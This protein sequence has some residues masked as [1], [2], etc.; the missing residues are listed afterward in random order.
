MNRCV[1]VRKISIFKTS[2]AILSN[3]CIC[4]FTP[5]HALHIRPTSSTRKTFSYKNAS[6]HYRSP[7]LTPLGAVCGTVYYGWM[8]FTA[9]ILDCWTKA[10]KGQDILNITLTGFVWKKNLIWDAPRMPWA[11]VGGDGLLFIFGW[12]NHLT[13]CYS[14]LALLRIYFPV[15]HCK[16]AL[17]QSV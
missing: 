13:I 8:C 2:E 11:W 12:T 16:A 5:A 7:L 10:R 4:H 3:F 1:F 15:W 17:T 14:P 6:I 9:L